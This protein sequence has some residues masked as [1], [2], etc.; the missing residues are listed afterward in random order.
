MCVIGSEAF[1]K[2]GVD[3]R[4]GASCQRGSTSC[5]REGRHPQTSYAPPA[6]EAAGAA[7]AVVHVAPESQEVLR[8][9]D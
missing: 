1:G 2:N 4:F 9:G 5:F 8:G 6:C 7:D 3:D